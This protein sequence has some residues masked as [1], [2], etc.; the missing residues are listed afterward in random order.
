VN[1]YRPNRRFDE[2]FR[3]SDEARD[4]ALAR[5]RDGAEIARSLAP[6]ASGAYRDSI[7]ASVEKTGDGWKGIVT[8]GVSHAV[9]V[10][11]GTEDTPV[12]ATLRRAGEI[13]EKE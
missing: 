13:V 4:Y 7:E 2:A 3:H 11:F 8:A 6:V 10:E 5:A 1:L 9:Y 12:F